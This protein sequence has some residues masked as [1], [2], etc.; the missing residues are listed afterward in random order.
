MVLGLSRLRECA[1]SSVGEECGFENGGTLRMRWFVVNK[2]SYDILAASR[3][4]ESSLNCVLCGVARIF[5]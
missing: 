1:E 3:H 4:A 2:N 5:S